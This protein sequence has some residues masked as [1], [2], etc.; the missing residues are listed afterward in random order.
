MVTPSF[1]RS[2]SAFDDYILL[3]RGQ[4]ENTA[5]TYRRSLTLWKKHCGEAALDPLEV[6]QANVQTFIARLKKENRANSSI[7]LIITALR[8][9]VKY[10]ILEGDLPADSWIPVLPAKSKKLPQSLTEGEIQ[11]IFDACSGDSYYDCR[12]R[13]A[14]EILASCGIRAS[15]LCGLLVGSVDLDDKSLRVVGK[16]S[17][18]R[19]V[20]FAGELKEQIQRY[21][22]ARE[23]FL[24]GD[25]SVKSLFLSSRR[26]PLNRIDL[27]RIVQKR[28]KMASIQ[29]SRLHPHVLRHSIA[30]HL[31]RR[32]MDL[33]TLQ[34][35][36]GHSSIAT[37][38]KYLHFD[39][40]LRDVYDR[41]HPRA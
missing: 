29:E 1:E 15:E 17:K 5:A 40:E 18:E 20:P 4:S 35:F 23:E 16:G 32:G 12:D 22:A 3:E 14:L 2:C 9:W 33:R 7:Q 39:M 30:T 13:T 6:S 11:R 19:I 25:R 31:L 26:E 21:L 28:G 24:K 37:T 27:W 34:E 8:S 38:E 10:R 36:L 41:S